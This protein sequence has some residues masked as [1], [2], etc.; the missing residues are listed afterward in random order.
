MQFSLYTVCIVILFND[1]QIMFS[2]ATTYIVAR[3]DS[4]KRFN[5]IIQKHALLSSII[6][7]PVLN[8]FINLKN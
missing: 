3:C 6:Y 2:H 5:Q 1:E 8:F 4:E 7:S